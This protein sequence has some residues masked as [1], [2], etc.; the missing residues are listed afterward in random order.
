M[1]DK[2]AE[3]GGAAE[4]KDAYGAVQSSATD[5]A[6][7]S[8][9]AVKQKRANGKEAANEK[10]ASEKSADESTSSSLLQKAREFFIGRRV[11]EGRE[12]EPISAQRRWIEQCLKLGS[13]D[14]GLSLSIFV[15]IERFRAFRG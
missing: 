12:D 10:A 3:D 1:T 5:E 8:G 13:K 11:Q 9:E 7:E 2:A 15:K 6:R 4:Q 14:A